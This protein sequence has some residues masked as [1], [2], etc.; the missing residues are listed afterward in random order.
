M[1]KRNLQ[2]T[3][4][5]L[6]ILW[7]SLTAQA[8]LVHA[9]VAD[10]AG[11]VTVT[12]PGKSTGN[13][14]NVAQERAIAVNN[15]PKAE[16]KGALQFTAAQIIDA[17]RVQLKIGEYSVQEPDKSVFLVRNGANADLQKLTLDKSGDNTSG[18][19][20]DYGGLNAAFLT[21]DATASLDS[22]TITTNGIG[23][24]GI[25]AT[26][27][28]GKVR[29]YNTVV[30]TASDASRGLVATAGASI[31]AGKLQINTSGKDSA[32]LFA[33]GDDATVLISG[34]QLATTGT[35]S[36][37]VYSMG[38]ISLVTSSGTAAE[39]EIAFVEGNNDLTLDAV[40]LTGGKKYGILLYGSLSK[41]AVPGT[42]VLAVRNSTLTSTAPEGLFYVTN[43]KAAASLEN[44]TLNFKGENAIRV[45]AGPWGTPGVNGADFVLSLIKQKLNGNIVVDK[46]STLTLNLGQESDWSGRVVSAGPVPK[47]NVN[48]K[49]L[50]R[51]SLGG[52]VHLDAFDDVDLKLSNIESNGYNIYY[53]PKNKSN[54]W[55]EGRAYRLIGGGKLVPELPR[56]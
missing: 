46:L 30:T 48:M 24:S 33:Y 32:A 49:V 37:L 55:L 10:R 23:A 6:T 22:C 16:L 1:L 26:G 13:R 28:N 18:E 40:N 17:N 34:S 5:L 44:C 41:D 8:P 15:L 31:S 2:V 35:D 39:S 27:L 7:T 42:G 4:L 9:E 29:A 56:K 14:N 50:S 53:N 11:Q 20:S 19:Y 51:W 45:E 54:K 12:V 21:T 38:T 52:D 43:T 47:V 25:F 36:P 3:G